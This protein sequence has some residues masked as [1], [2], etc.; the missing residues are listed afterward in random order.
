VDAPP[1]IPVPVETSSLPTGSFCN[2][3][4]SR[5][6]PDSAFCNKCGTPVVTD[7]ELEAHIA[8]KPAPAPAVPQIQIQSPPAFGQG[9]K[10]ERPI[11]E[12]IHSI[13][14]LIEDSVPRTQP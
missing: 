5:V 13:E 7:A 8:A 11:E 10:K 3:C 6:P 12:V 4:G 9:D 14:P 2:K 1:A